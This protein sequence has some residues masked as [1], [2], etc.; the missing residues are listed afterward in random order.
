MAN[1]KLFLIIGRIKII[2]WRTKKL[3][4]SILINDV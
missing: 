3:D 4:K 2:N 1:V